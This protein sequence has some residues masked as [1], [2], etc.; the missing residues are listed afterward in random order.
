MPELTVSMPAYN[1][2]RYIGRAIESVLQQAGVDLEL[3]VV[4]DASEDNT[5]EVALSFKDPR[6]KLFTNEI[7]RGISY[8][9]NLVIKRSI[10]PYIAHV[11]SDD[12]IVPHALQRM[13]Q[14]LKSDPRIGQV[15]C[16][17]VEIADDG[18]MST[19]PFHVRRN[20]FSKAGLS[21]WT[22]NE[23]C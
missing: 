18:T 20:R 7:N 16:Y 12:V 5:A 11:D 19:E 13:I 4:D 23:N 21:I 6:V 1:T 9:H 2:A 15:H 10:S 17:H 14:R 8:C 22:I 3:I